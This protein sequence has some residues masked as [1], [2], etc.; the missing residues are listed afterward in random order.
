MIATLVSELSR[1]LSDELILPFNCSSYSSQ[2]QIELKLFKNAYKE[3]LDE[4]NINLDKLELSISNFIA[5][6]RN[7]HTK[8]SALDK[9]Q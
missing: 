7:F 5:A 3:K 2:L 6:A 9:K 4:L 8:L 1:R